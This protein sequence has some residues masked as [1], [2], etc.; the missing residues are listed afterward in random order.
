MLKSHQTSF[1]RVKWTVYMPEVNI[2]STAANVT[3]RTAKTAASP[4]SD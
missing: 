2:D 4:A 3:K 1:H